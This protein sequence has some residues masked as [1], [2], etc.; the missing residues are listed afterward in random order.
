MKKLKILFVSL[1]T[2]AGFD[3]T[4]P[5]F[6]QKLN[7]KLNNKFCCVLDQYYTRGALCL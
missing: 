7:N 6:A 5:N 1:H 2:K 3:Y 4:D